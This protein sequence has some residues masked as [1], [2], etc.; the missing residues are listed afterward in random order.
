M[1]VYVN[2]YDGPGE[3]VLLL[4]GIGGSADSFTGQFAALSARHRVLAWDAPGYAR[5]AAPWEAPRMTGYAAT[6]AA[7]L[8]ER[9]AVPAHV[10]G[11]SW[12]G[13][14]AT[15]LALEHPEVVRSLVLVDSTRGSGRTA[16]Q[17]AA[18]RR[19]ADELAEVGPDAFARAR[20][21]RLLSA[22]APP[23]LAERVAT[24]MARSIRLPGYAYAAASMAETDHDDVLGRVSV[25]T[26]V[27][28]G[29]RDVVTGVTESEAIAAAVPGARFEV[30]E[31]AGHLSNVECPEEFNRLVLEFLS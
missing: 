9:D 19:R 10:V 11:V 13:V 17:A 25:P 16:E 20:A 15:R 5:S 27:I 24:A 2:E 26:L 30:I 6:A 3:P 23:E 7:V 21:P 12:G 31:G 1:T 18:M 14:I 22:E 29:D 4:H 8:R 28:A